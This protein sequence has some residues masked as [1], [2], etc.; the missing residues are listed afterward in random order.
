MWNRDS[1]RPTSTP[2]DYHMYIF[3]LKGKGYANRIGN[4]NDSCGNRDD[5][6]ENGKDKNRMKEEAR[7][8]LYRTVCYFGGR[9]VLKT[10][11][12]LSP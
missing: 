4:G 6:S 9:G 11:A 3:M 12:V 1:A 2:Q 5:K 7:Q 8:V 10:F